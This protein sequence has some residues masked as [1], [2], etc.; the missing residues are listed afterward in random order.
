MPEPDGRRVLT[1]RFIRLKHWCNQL[2]HVEVARLRRD[3]D[4]GLFWHTSRGTRT[5]VE[6]R[7][8][9]WAILWWAEIPDPPPLPERE[10]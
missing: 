7:E 2:D 1:V 8:P 3:P 5:P 6:R 4:G 9:P 10:Q